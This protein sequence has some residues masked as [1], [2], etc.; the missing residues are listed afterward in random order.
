PS[1]SMSMPTRWTAYPN[2][3]RPSTRPAAVKTRERVD[4]GMTLTVR[5]Y[6]STGGATI[7]RSNLV[8]TTPAITA[9]APASLGSVNGSPSQMA[10][11][12]RAPLGV[13]FENTPAR[14]PPSFCTAVY[15]ITYAT[16]SASSADAK[17]AAQATAL[18]SVHTSER[19]PFQAT[20]R[21]RRAP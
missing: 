14:E 16:K 11:V 18:T 3:T 1:T 17:R 7:L 5:L 9:A 19:S 2:S 21:Y 15:Q 4:L 8:T 10:A 12:T 6:A 13:P 20:G